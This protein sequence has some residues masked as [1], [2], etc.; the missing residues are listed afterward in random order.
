MSALQSK[1]M[2]AGIKISMW[3][4]RKLDRKVTDETNVAK[5]ASADAGRYNK[6]LLAKSALAE[7]QEIAGRARK[8]CAARTLPWADSGQRILSATGYDEFT[9]AM[10]GISYEFEAARI[11]VRDNFTA[12]IEDAR[13]SL[14]EMF[15]PA[16]Y[17]TA[18]EV[19]ER[20][21]YKVQIWPMPSAADFRVDVGDAE[22]ARI[23]ADIQSE[24]DAAMS[25][26]VKDVY[27]RIHA[28]TSKMAEALN[29]YVPPNP[30]KKGDRGEKVFHNSLVENVRELATLLPSLNFTGDAGIASMAAELAKL[31]KHDA[32]DLK[33]S[34]SIRA[35][36]AREAAK[37][38]SHV[39][40]YM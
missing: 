39:S 22:A 34:D 27:G 36:I 3:S 35:T 11:K 18:D 25:E 30:D 38:A 8:T 19:F 7:I 9:K 28:V 5:G 4:A 24:F 16:D 12:Y 31:T 6:A 20:F 14:G 33:D 1:A 32:A 13:A 10:R 2:L 21:R 15:D 37:I 17:P 26:A 23:R 40:D 29:A